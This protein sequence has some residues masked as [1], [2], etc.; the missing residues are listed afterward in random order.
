MKRSKHGLISLS[1]DSF[2][3]KVEELNGINL[4]VDICQFANE[5]SIEHSIDPDISK[6][7]LDVL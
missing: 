6:K 3:E 7:I 5:K 4:Y 2:I 1:L